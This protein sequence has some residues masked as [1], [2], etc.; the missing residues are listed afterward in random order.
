MKPNLQKKVAVLLILIGEF[1]CGIGSGQAAPART[2]EELLQGTW[3][4]VSAEKDGN[5]PADVSKGRVVFKGTKITLG[6]EGQPGETF[7]F[8]FSP[9]ANPKGITLVGPGDSKDSV[10]GIYKL[11]GDSLTLCVRGKSGRAKDA[12]PD[13]LEAQPPTKFSSE[14]CLLIVL[15]RKKQ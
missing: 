14:G 4:V 8:K 6:D 2:D 1:A 10:P 7:T 15:T 12:P 11:D 9:K 13:P 3:V 5:K